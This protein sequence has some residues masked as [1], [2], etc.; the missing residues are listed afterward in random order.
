MR[1][2]RVRTGETL[3]EALIAYL[4]PVVVPCVGRKLVGIR[5]GSSLLDLSQHSP[6][7]RSPYPAGI[8]LYILSLLLCSH[9][10]APKLL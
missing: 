3:Q 1:R 10:E 7:H 2:L 9:K 8:K 6:S 5:P 4:A